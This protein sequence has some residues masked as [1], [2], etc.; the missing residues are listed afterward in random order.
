M[1]EFGEKERKKRRRIGKWK[2]RMKG[3]GCYFVW[4]LPF[5]LSDLYPSWK[6]DTAHGG[7]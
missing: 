4:P 3:R 2:G 1:A 5:N 7:C 6:G